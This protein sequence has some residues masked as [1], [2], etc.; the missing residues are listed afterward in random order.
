L[1]HRIESKWVLEAND[2]DMI[3]MWHRFKYR[4]DG[5]T[6]EITSSLITLGDDTIYTAMSKTVGLP[7]AMAAKRI[8]RGEWKL[9]GVTLPVYPEIY[10]PILEE[11]RTYGI[12]FQ[13]RH[14]RIPEGH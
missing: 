8:L 5:E 9:S 14:K 3:V 1:Q 7:I 6:H 4:L 2:K 12:E 13:E 10:I 11:L